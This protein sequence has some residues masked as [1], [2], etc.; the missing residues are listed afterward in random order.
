MTN[1]APQENPEP[2]KGRR[3][4]LV[5]ELWHFMSVRKKY[6]LAPIFLALLILALLILAASQSGIVAPFIYAL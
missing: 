3:E 4:I 1:E 2:R 5:V 6:W